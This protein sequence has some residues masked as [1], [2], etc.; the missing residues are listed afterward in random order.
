MHHANRA[1][2]FATAHQKIRIKGKT[3]HIIDQTR[4]RLKGRISHRGFA[5]INRDRRTYL[6]RKRPDNRCYPRNFFLNRNFNRPR[7][8]RL[9]TNIDKIGPVLGHLNRLLNRK[10]RI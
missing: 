10:V 6:L 8:R 3:G 4:A 9:A 1:H 2:I 7:P 5:R